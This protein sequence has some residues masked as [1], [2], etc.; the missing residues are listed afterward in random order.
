MNPK[1]QFQIKKLLQELYQ[2]VVATRPIAKGKS[3]SGDCFVG[4]VPVWSFEFSYWELFGIWC[5]YLGISPSST[6]ATA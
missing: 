2:S 4:P 1:F 6:R 5:L 3:T